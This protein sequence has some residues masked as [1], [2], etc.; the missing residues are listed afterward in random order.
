[1]KRCP[2]CDFIYLDTDDV[3]DLDGAALITTDETE[4]SL[5]PTDSA[6]SLLSVPA[7]KRRRPLIAAALTGLIL[8]VLL[9]FA[10]LGVVRSREQ[11]HVPAIKR[12][13]A[14]SA[15]EVTTPGPTPSPTPEPTPTIT[16]KSNDVSVTSTRVAL[17]KN[18]VSTST[19]GIPG[20]AVIRL[21]NGVAIEADEVW[22]TREGVWYRRS[23]IV[24]FIK[25][26]R[27]RSIEKLSPK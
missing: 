20:R 6:K 24:T 4:P 19:A 3:C 1:M 14:A 22:R 12:V 26:N 17:S 13:I 21:Q 16:L 10:Y 11:V 18:P 5:R 15:I 23:G 8:G 7:T 27:V 25:A 9:F 2:Q